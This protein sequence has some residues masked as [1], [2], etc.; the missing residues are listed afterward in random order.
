MLKR[1]ALV[2]LIAVFAVGTLTASG[3][4]GVTK[5]EKKYTFYFFSVGFWHPFLIANIHGAQEAAAKYPIDLVVL[6]GRNDPGFQANQVIT[7]IA[8]KPD[9]FII[10]CVT[11][12]G[13]V[14]ALKEV[15]ESGH[16]RL[17]YGQGCGGFQPASRACRIQPSADR[18]PG[19]SVRGRLSA[20]IRLPKPWK[21]V[22]LQG[23]VGNIGNTER[24]KGWYEASI[25][26]SSPE[27]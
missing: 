3:Q 20:E 4:Q 13:L 11:E 22:V 27:T 24:V 12:Q 21:V 8:K 16:P 18:Q 7:A 14:P 23:L 19:W 15:S 5:A 2:L 9:M 10:D 26:L 17:L 1:I 25:P 6:D